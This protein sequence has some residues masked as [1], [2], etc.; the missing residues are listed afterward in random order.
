MMLKQI[1]AILAATFI[2]FSSSWAGSCLS[3]TLAESTPTSRFSSADETVTDQETTLS[4]MRCA[5]GQRWDG[6]SCL[7]QPQTVAWQEAM[8]MVDKVNAQGLGGYHDWRMP[9]IP[10]L[11]SIV[12]RQCFNPRMNTT[13]FPGAPSAVFW[14]S[15]EKMGTTNY[16]YTLD[17]GGG[18]ALA[19][20]KQRQGAVRLVRGGPWWVPPK[21]SQR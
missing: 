16:A 7:G 9:M 1:M 15:M 19:S 13:V 17:F 4:W 11:A 6:S 8:A 18:A 2:C 21:M 3:E 5:V 14:S 20:D 12:E 10:E